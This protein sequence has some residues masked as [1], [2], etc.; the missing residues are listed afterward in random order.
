[1]FK[2]ILIL[3]ISIILIVL[4]I[5]IFYIFRKK[6]LLYSDT[7]LKYPLTKKD[8]H[9]FTQG[10]MLS[11]LKHNDIFYIDQ[12]WSTKNNNYFSFNKQY[13][14]IEPGYYYHFLKDSE[15]FIE[16]DN[17]TFLFQKNK[18]NEKVKDV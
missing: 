10:G 18:I 1:M 6:E 8:K 11:E 9:F 12:K 13:Y 5:Y 17:I 7:I 3:C 15:I 16:N 2:H 4:L 14:I